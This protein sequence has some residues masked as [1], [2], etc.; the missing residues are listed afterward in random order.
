MIPFNVQFIDESKGYVIEWSWDF[1]DN[2]TSQAQNPVHEYGKSSYVY[3]TP[4]ACF[5]PGSHTVKLTVWTNQE[6]ATKIAEDLIAVKPEEHTV[7]L[8]P[9]PY[10]LKDY[11]KLLHNPGCSAVCS[12]DVG[13]MTVGATI[14]NTPSNR[15]EK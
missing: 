2:E 11:V 5:E 8:Q 12:T 4:K 3:N 6:S 1:G 13:G 10:A 14:F 15:V 7:T 9:E